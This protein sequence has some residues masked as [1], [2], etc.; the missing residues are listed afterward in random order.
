MPG[1]EE[2]IFSDTSFPAI[3]DASTLHPISFLGGMGRRIGERKFPEEWHRLMNAIPRPNMKQ[4]GMPP[5][6]RVLVD[7]GDR[8]YA[9]MAMLAR[10]HHDSDSAE[11]YDMEVEAIAAPM[12]STEYKHCGPWAGVFR[13]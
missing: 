5:E 10:F 4:E 8:A 3:L 11:F 9:Q 13:A 7:F 2:V 12:D 6:Q 1:D